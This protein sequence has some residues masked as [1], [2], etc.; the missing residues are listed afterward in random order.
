MTTALTWCHFIVPSGQD[1]ERVGPVQHFNDH[2]QL[3]AILA[4]ECQPVVMEFVVMFAAQ[5]DC[6][7]VMGFSSHSRD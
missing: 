2:L 1:A 3:R 7:D 5:W 6:E 4:L